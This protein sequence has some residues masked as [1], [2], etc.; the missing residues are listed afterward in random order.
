MNRIFFERKDSYLLSKMELKG[1]VER[2]KCLRMKFCITMYK[3]SNDIVYI[4]FVHKI[5]IAL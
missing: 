4:R 1:T 5:S 3:A 2:E